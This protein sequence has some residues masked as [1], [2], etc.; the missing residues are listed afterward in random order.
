MYTN[1]V[2]AIAKTQDYSPETKAILVL[3]AEV[4]ADMH[5][6]IVKISEAS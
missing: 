2:A 4:M 5:E 1:L 3:A 6:A